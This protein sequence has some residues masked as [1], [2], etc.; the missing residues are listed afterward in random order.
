[1]CVC[2][3]GGGG[4]HM[5]VCVCSDVLLT[6]FIM[7]FFHLVSHRWLIASPY[8]CLLTGTSHSYLMWMISARELVQ[9]VSRILSTVFLEDNCLC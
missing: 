8:P 7:Y 6:Y 3:E 5:Y 9:E 1:M 4:M 2:V